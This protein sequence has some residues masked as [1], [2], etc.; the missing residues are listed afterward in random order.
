M[1]EVIAAAALLF[2][3]ISLILSI[4]TKRAQDRLISRQIMAHDRE[5]EAANR[6]NIT[7]R[8]EKEPS[9]AGSS[10]QWK[11]VLGNGGP[12]DARD[13]RLEF[14]EPQQ[15]V[16]KS[17]LAGKLPLSLLA[18][19]EEVRLIASRAMGQPSKYDIVLKW[20]DSEPRAVER[21]LVP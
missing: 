3:G 5:A 17:E 16:P 10:A 19:G 1:S 14:R 12:A 7:A 13:V 9:W 20:T 2:S 11:L 18:S 6:A 4:R 15:L 8:V 21:V